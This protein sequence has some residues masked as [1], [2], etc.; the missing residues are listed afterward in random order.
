MSD[1]VIAFLNQN[2]HPDAAYSRL[3]FSV[4]LEVKDLAT[5]HQ[6]LPSGGE[7]KLLLVRCHEWFEPSVSCWLIVCKAKALQ[8]VRTAVELQK[9]CEGDKLVKHSSSAV[10]VVAM[11][12]QLRDFW[13]LLQWPKAHSIPLL[14]QLLDCICSA[15][16]LYADMTYQGLMES[17]YFDRLG[18]FKI[19]D[20]MCMA[21]NNLEYVY[22]FVSL[23]GLQH[24]KK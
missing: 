9:P 22:K 17:G 8:R 4:Y 15:A 3:I 6:N 11:F 14:S 19:C 16:L 5:F 2:E 10:D 23:L 12:C 21:S 20:E 7:H 18:P 1:E 13:R 24:Y